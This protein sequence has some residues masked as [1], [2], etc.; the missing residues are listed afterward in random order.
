MVS[1]SNKFNKSIRTRV[2][3]QGY[4]RM[5][6]FDAQDFQNIKENKENIALALRGH[7][8][9]GTFIINVTIHPQMFSIVPNSLYIYFKSMYQ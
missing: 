3:V 4:Y 9:K 7:S 5:N 6:T 2:L 1:I 8:L